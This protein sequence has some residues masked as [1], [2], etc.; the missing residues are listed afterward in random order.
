[1]AMDVY[2]LT[3]IAINGEQSDPVVIDECDIISMLKMTKSRNKHLHKK[4]LKWY[5]QVN[6]GVTKKTDKR[7]KIQGFDLSSILDGIEGIV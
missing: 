4:L 6:E 3:R 7:G 2:H 5:K 1:M